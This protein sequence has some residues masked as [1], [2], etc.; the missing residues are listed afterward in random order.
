[1]VYRLASYVRPVD[2][3]EGELYFRAL[4][5]PLFMATEQ[6][7]YRVREVLTGVN[8]FLVRDPDGYLVRNSSS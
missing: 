4:G 8:Q 3:G 7:W 1:V 2:C 6:K 5:W